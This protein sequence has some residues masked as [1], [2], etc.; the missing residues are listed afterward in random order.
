MQV[1]SAIVDGQHQ[2]SARCALVVAVVAGLAGLA[3]LVF[4]V[5]A[6]VAGLA[7]P[8]RSG[9]C[10]PRRIGQHG[11]V[12]LHGP[13][14]GL[15]PR[16]WRITRCLPAAP[17]RARASGSSSAAPQSGGQ[18]LG[19]ARLG[20]E[21]GL[22]VGSCDF[23]QRPPVVATRGTPQAIAS[24]AGSEKPSYSEGTTASSASA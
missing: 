7:A 11:A 18:R 12:L 2:R 13:L 14:G 1:E 8:G 22:S 3:A 20:Q 10:G 23:G 5:F 6:V 17:T 4:A 24:M 15:A 21:A 9:R 16:H 19:V